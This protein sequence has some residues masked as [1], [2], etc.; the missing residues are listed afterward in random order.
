MGDSLSAV[1]CR[2]LPS[3]MGAIFGRHRWSV[4]VYKAVP[5]KKDGKHT[6]RFDKNIGDSTMGGH[7]PPAKMEEDARTYSSQ[8]SIMYIKNLKHGE[9]CEISDIELLVLTSSRA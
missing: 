3:G 9:T 8:N 1:T 7:S 6:W 5:R 4:A 2:K